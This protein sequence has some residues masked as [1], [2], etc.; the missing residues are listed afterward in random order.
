MNTVQ[1][2]ERISGAFPFLERF[3]LNKPRSRLLL[4]LTAS[5]R[6]LCG[7]IRRLQPFI[8]FPNMIPY[9]CHPIS[10]GYTY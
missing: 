4:S 8:Y 9:R 5:R 2:E 1:P 7:V 6:M 10:E 3:S